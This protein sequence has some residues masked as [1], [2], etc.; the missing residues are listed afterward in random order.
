MAERGHPQASQIIIGEIQR[1]ENLKKRGNAPAEKKAIADEWR[2]LAMHA[3]R[4][5]DFDWTG[6]QKQAGKA[7]ATIPSNLSLAELGK[8]VHGWHQ[9]G[10][11]VDSRSMLAAGN[12][13]GSAYRQVTKPESHGVGWREFLEKHAGLSLKDVLKSKSGVR[14]PAKRT[15][16][17]DLGEEL[18]I[19]G[20]I[21]ELHKQKQGAQG[22]EED[23]LRK[24]W[25][26]LN[27][28]AVRRGF[29]W[30]DLQE[31]A[32]LA[33]KKIPFDP[34]TT[35]EQIQQMVLGWKNQGHKI[36]SRSLVET[37]GIKGQAYRHATEVLKTPW[38]QVL[39]AIGV[40]RDREYASTL[41]IPKTAG[42]SAQLRKTPLTRAYAGKADE[43]DAVELIRGHPGFLEENPEQ[44]I[45]REYEGLKQ[46]ELALTAKSRNI[47]PQAGE[48]WR[49]MLGEINKNIIDIRKQQ[50]LQRDK[51]RTLE[52]LREILAKL[53]TTP[54]ELIKKHGGLNA[55][56]AVQAQREERVA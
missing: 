17:L 1:L 42:L 30:N 10:A 24:I 26:S 5:H 32:G 6:L 21:K 16:I 37:G 50:N 33:P 22:R 40:K 53:R 25:R 41:G 27:M 38:P 2:A 18:E 36:D 14:Q 12:D 11:K 47:D 9:Q 8:L 20:R 52:K 55:Q 51:I 43:L 28:R 34:N 31:K 35:I 15:K 54:H 3:T 4:T 13:F 29:D 56:K 45:K 19:I 23:K 39:K 7:F 48:Q 44:R 46:R 49:R